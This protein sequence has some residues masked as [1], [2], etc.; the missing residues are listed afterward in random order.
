MIQRI[1]ELENILGQLIAEHRKLLAYMET[2]QGGMKK[3]D[4]QKMD[5]T[6]QLQEACRLRL[7]GLEQRRRAV[8]A[9]IAKLARVEGNLT[10]TQI[11][12]LHPPRAAALLKLRDELKSLAEQVRIRAH[13]AG[14]VA[15]AVLGHLNKVVRLL[16]GAVEK[17]GI[18][19]K[20][21]VPQV[22]KRIGLMET[23][24]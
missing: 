23:V 20:N 10:V 19:N 7:S 17:A 5:E 11:A 2:Q 8:V 24:G 15:G 4:L 18:Y 12:A 3:L 14:R 21:G 9:Q 6:A 1:S 13:I 22:S 16:A